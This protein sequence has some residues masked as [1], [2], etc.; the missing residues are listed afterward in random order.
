MISRNPQRLHHL[1]ML[2]LL[3]A[4][5][6]IALSLVSVRVPLCRRLSPAAVGRYWTNLTRPIGAES[7]QSHGDHLCE[8]SRPLR[9]G[10][11]R[12]HGHGTSHA[13]RTRMKSTTRLSVKYRGRRSAPP[14]SGWR[15]SRR[16]AAHIPT[17]FVSGDP[18]ET[19]KAVVGG[20]TVHPSSSSPPRKAQ[21]TST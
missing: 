19:G 4:Q 6:T 16:D 17:V 13:P 5:L 11:H 10:Q 8:R 18:R 20:K 7:S 14:Q 21:S 2:L 1:F 15:V 12:E 9:V 3:T